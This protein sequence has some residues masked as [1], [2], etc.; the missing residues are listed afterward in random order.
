[1]KRIK[2]FTIIE[3]L[4]AMLLS[5]VVVICA[6][7]AYLA[8]VQQ[9]QGSQ[10]NLTHFYDVS[11]VSHLIEKDLFDSELAIG[12]ASTLKLQYQQNDSIMYLFN[13]NEIVRQKAGT[14][15]TFHFAVKKIEFY[16]NGILIDN[17]DTVSGF[18]IEIL[19]REIQKSFTL[20]FSFRSF[21][22]F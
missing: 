16:K 22:N 2:A 4:I 9:F 11:T 10:K 20:C 6:Y 1:M 7:L 19:E 17:T 5:S 18:S 3:V 21:N 13:E 8:L 12:S 15:D 14:D